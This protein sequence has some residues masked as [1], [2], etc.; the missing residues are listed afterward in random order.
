MTEMLF[1][2]LFP[3]LCKARPRC[4]EGWL[5]SSATTRAAPAPPNQASWSW[6]A[7]TRSARYHRISHLPINYHSPLPINVS[8]CSPGVGFWKA[9]SP[10]HREAFH[11]RTTTL[12]DSV[13]AVIT[14]I[15]GHFP[16]SSVQSPVKSPFPANPTFPVALG[17]EQH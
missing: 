16:F 15:F 11:Q 4:S 14:T 9:L 12:F 3:L 6:S 10:V 13:F 8:C 1:P 2:P 17:P 5:N 7:R